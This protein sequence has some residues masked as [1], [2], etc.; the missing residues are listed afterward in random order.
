MIRSRG[1]ARRDQAFPASGSARC[2]ARPAVGRW[3]CVLLFAV[4]AAFFAT[5]DAVASPRYPATA[6]QETAVLGGTNYIDAHRLMVRFGLD[7]EWLKPSRRA[8]FSS[9]WTTVELETDSRE[10]LFNGLRVFLGD[11]V[12]LHHGHLWISRVDAEKIIGPLLKPAL[13]ADTAR[14]PQVIVIDAGHGGTDT[15]TRNTK[16]KL[17]EKDH[18]LD[19]AKQLGGILSRE[20]YRVLYTREDDRFIPLEDRAAFSNRA[21]AD[22]FVSVHF[23]AAV[24]EVHGIET[25]ILTPQYQRSTGQAKRGDG[26]GEVLPGHRADPW[27][28]VLGYQIHRQLVRELEP[29]DRGLK[30]ARFL[31]LREVE[32]PAVLV[33]AGYLS[34]EAEA[35]KIA[36]PAYRSR[37]AQAIA[38]GI[39]TYASQ[40]ATARKG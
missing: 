10:I 17:D 16:L 13:H 29:V 14:R 19:L 34:N 36:T 11:G 37:I 30:R 31:V 26:D 4:A 1:R 5:A 3:G 33:E 32:C 24:P 22:L 2:A 40:V 20:G 15:G 27:N 35:R 7:E 21:K 38:H 12:M 23:N 28:A 6:G 25:Y 9:A 8:K 18:A 39:A